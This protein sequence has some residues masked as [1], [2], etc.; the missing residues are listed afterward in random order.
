MCSLQV[1]LCRQ[2]SIQTE[3]ELNRIFLNEEHK[4][5]AQSYFASYLLF[6]Q[7]PVINL[8]LCPGM[9]S[10]EHTYKGPEG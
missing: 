7:R 4:A 8:G 2:H 9:C 1:T 6:P 10:D 5:G 3:L